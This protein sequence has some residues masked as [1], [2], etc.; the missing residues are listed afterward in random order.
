MLTR[1]W[2]LAGLGALASSGCYG[3]FLLTRKL[4]EWNGSFGDKW[5][6]TIVFWVFV[7]LPVYGIVTFVDAVALN[8]V[9]FWTGSNPMATLEHEDGSE[10]RF[11]RLDTDRVRIE[12]VERGVTVRSFE[13]VI[14]GP[15]AVM[16]VDA[17]GEVLGACEGLADGSL[18]VTR[19]G[20]PV[21][22][23]ADAVRALEQ[24]QSKGALAEGLLQRQAALAAR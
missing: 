5:L 3:K 19:E 13:V 21:H 1:R 7:I 9:E 2:L 17:R 8:L 11:T 12:R 23:S 20:Q 15:S 24:S 10:T 22:V 18:V 4:Y 6:R 14:A 16:A